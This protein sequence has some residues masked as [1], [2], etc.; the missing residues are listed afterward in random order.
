MNS[1]LDIHINVEKQIY[2]S[3]DDSL[4]Q[5]HNIRTLPLFNFQTY[6]YIY[7]YTKNVYR[8]KCLAIWRQTDHITW[9]YNYVA[10]IW[11]WQM[12]QLID[13]YDVNEYSEVQNINNHNI[14]Q[15]FQ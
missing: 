9:K 13:F 2:R 14:I 8:K 12:R 10:I 5:V 1:L 7:Y 11:I 6:Y 4:H 15:F 3:S